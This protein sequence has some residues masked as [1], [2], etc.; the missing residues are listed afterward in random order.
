[1]KLQIVEYK[2]QNILEGNI[3]YRYMLE[4]DEKAVLWIPPTPTKESSEKVYS[5][6]M[7]K[8]LDKNTDLK[9]EHCVRLSNIPG[10]NREV[11]FEKEVS[12][13]FLKELYI[14]RKMK[15]IEEDFA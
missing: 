6:L 1:M 14:E 5:I 12:D 8:M 9:F 7:N 11:I 4:L 15:D 13:T 10:V 2:F 3:L